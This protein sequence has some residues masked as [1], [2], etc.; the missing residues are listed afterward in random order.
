MAYTKERKRKK[1]DSKRNRCKENA[2]Q[3]WTNQKEFNNFQ[4]KKK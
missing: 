4:K 2:K 1:K 3:H